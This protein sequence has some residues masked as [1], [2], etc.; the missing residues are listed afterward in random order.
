[1]HLVRIGEMDRG[2]KLVDV[3]AAH[4]RTVQMISQHGA[5]QRLPR[6]RGAM[7]GQNQ[8]PL[9]AFIVKEPCHFLGDNVLSQMLSID[10]LVEIPLQVWMKTKTVTTGM[11]VQSICRIY[12]SKTLSF[13]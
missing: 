10:V 13:G 1:M 2:N 5:D 9:W 4:R 12:T 8:G 6:P 11:L 7:E 3:W